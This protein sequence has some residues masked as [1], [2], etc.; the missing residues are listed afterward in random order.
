MNNQYHQAG[1]R[2]SYYT[3]YAYDKLHLMI[4]KFILNNK[5]SM[6]KNY[7]KHRTNLGDSYNQSDFKLRSSLCLIRITFIVDVHSTFMKTTI[8]LA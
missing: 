7:T 4:N 3:I 8:D 1:R 6:I 5:Y 2:N